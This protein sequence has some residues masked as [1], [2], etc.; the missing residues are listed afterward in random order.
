MRILFAAAASIALFVPTARA[1][2]FD[3][4]VVFG[5]SLSDNGNAYIATG[6]QPPA[7]VPPAYTLGRF[8]D[9]PD[10]FPSTTQA[11]LLW[12]EV[13]AG[14]LGE[15]PAE[16]FLAGGTNYAVGGAQVLQDVPVGPLTNPS[17]ASPSGYNTSD[18]NQVFGYLESVGGHPDPNALY[19][20]WGGANDLYNAIETPGETPAGIAGTE[21]EMAAALDQAIQTLAGLGAEHFLWLNLPQLATTP[22][23]MADI[24]QAPGLAAAFT[25]ASTQF[26]AAVAAD[27]A[28]LNLLPGVQVIPVDIYSLYQEI[29]ADPANFGYTN[30]TGYAQGKAVNP[31]Q[32]L[33]WDPAS[34]PTTTGQALIA[35]AAFDDIVPEPA[36]WTLGSAGLLF[37]ILRKRRPAA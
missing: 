32:Y 6:G 3:Q 37:I 20:F 22:R 4:F 31:D 21:A 23:G 35:R 28:A 33:F 25:A 5:D 10:T 15:P 27:S 30:V 8:T 29:M 19:I 13:L 11:P 2:L 9:G 34:H 36:T 26:Q 14:L 1:S 18:P 12:H 16:P 7:P 24:Q 17:I